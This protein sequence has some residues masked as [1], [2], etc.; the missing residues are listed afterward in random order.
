MFIIPIID[1]RC[2]KEL[3]LRAPLVDASVKLR[4]RI[5]SHL[6]PAEDDTGYLS[7]LIQILTFFFFLYGAGASKS[8]HAI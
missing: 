8:A 5:K 4:T 2:P 7:L 3:E 1:Y 6:H